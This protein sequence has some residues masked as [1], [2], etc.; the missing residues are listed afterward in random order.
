M[1]FPRH[2]WISHNRHEILSIR[3]LKFLEI[4]QIEIVEN[5]DRLALSVKAS[6][7]DSIIL[8]SHYF[9]EANEFRTRSYMDLMRHKR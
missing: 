8:R 2:F 3:V 7:K 5:K 4:I 1:L 9:S 6:R